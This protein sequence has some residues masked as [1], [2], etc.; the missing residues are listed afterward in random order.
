MKPPLPVLSR[1]L[2]SLSRV[3]N[4]SRPPWRDFVFPLLFGGMCWTVLNFF[5]A[6]LFA[7]EPPQLNVSS[8]FSNGSGIVE[9][10]D[11]QKRIIR[12]NPSEHK[13]RGWVCWWY[14]KVS[15]IKPGE[16]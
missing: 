1:P 9:K 8:D 5:T 16:T 10:I 14:V 3:F 12:L 11:Q 2:I 4:V 7:S 6:S 13:D 15:G